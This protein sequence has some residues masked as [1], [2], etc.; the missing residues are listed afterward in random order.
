MF[1]TCG[2]LG[3]EGASSLLGKH[4]LCFAC[5]RDQLNVSSHLQHFLPGQLT[6][7]LQWNRFGKVRLVV[8]LLHLHIP[9]PL[10]RLAESFRPV[11]CNLTFWDITGSLRD[12]IDV[13]LAA[14]ILLD[15]NI[16]WGGK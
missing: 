3:F 9:Q 4:N 6:V 10:Q 2:L 16:S 12:G 11:E 5:G 14:D 7:R 13:Q 8:L 15:V 1:A